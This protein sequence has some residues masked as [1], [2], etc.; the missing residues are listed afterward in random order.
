MANLIC[1][2]CNDNLCFQDYKGTKYLNEDRE[3]PCFECLLEAG[4]FDEEEEEQT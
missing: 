3:K 4:A 1:W 2:I